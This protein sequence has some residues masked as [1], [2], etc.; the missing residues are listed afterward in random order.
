MRITGCGAT[1]RIRRRTEANSAPTSHRG[2][3]GSRRDNHRIRVIERVEVARVELLD[4]EALKKRHRRE[5]VSVVLD[6]HG[7]GS[8]P[9]GEQPLQGDW[10]E[11]P[12]P[13]RTPFTAIDL[14]DAGCGDEHR[15]TRREG[16]M[17]P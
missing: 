7:T 16:A 15:A 14:A 3:D 8:E 11:R 13:G 9:L 2:L 1:P 17:K 5:D 4:G 10:R 12:E 6:H